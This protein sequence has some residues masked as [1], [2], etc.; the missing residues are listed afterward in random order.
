[1][2]VH[3]GSAIAAVPLA[4]WHVM[5]RW[6]R[7]RPV[8]LA[9]RSLLRGG[10][11]LAAAGLAYA[12]LEGVVRISALPGAGRRFTGSYEIASFQPE[13]MPVTQWMFDQVP[14]IDASSWSLAVQANG[15]VR[16][17]GYEE[18]ADFDDRVVATLDCT[19]GFYSAQEWAGVWMSRLIPI[20]SGPLSLRVR[21]VT[22]YDRRF[23]TRDAP[24]LLIAT[25]IGGIPLTAGQGYPVRI[26]A[27]DRRGFWWVKWL[28]AIEASDAPSWWQ[29]PFPIQ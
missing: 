4:L 13:G 28:S 17:W 26:V 23:S 7:P 16:R 22:G 14:G 20:G 24:R 12:A 1:M 9:R 10:V 11:T 25:R 15:V 6:I 8:D 2:E 5:A 19:G 21:S 18:L 3:V 27:P 29:L